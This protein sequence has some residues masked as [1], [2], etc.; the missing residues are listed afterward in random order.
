MGCSQSTRIEPEAL[1]PEDSRTIRETWKL[2]GKEAY[3]EFG[4]RLMLRIFQKHPDIKALWQTPRAMN[5]A[6]T[7]VNNDNDDGQ[8]KSENRWKMD[9]RNHGSKFFISI[10]ELITHIDNPE[11]LFR[12]LEQI[13]ARHKTYGVKTE[14]IQAVVEGFNHTMEFGLKDKWTDNRQKAFGRLI[15]IIVARINRAIDGKTDDK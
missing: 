2:L 1:T 15:N 6:P 8:P 5:N 12:H 4:T 9:L 3:G 13:G 7:T 11:D 10:E 14:H